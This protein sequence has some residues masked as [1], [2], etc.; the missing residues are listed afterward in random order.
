M[1][2]IKYS[3]LSSSVLESWFTHCT[4]W[5]NLTREI[6]IFTFVNTKKAKNENEK[7]TIREKGKKMKKKIVPRV[8][9]E[10][11]TFRCLMYD[12]ETDALPTALT[13]HFLKI[14][15]Q[16][17][18][19]NTRSNGFPQVARDFPKIFP[20]FLKKSLKSCS[21]NNQKLLFVMKVAQ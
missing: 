15:Q 1:A 11:T 12:Y 13:R 20:Q 4:C 6:K 8:R 21:K 7:Q 9:I 3:P 17:S 14:Q 10:L 2:L 5:V 18:L 16:K 19:I